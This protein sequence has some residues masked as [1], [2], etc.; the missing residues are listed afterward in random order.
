MEYQAILF[1]PSGDFVKDFRGCKSK[2]EVWKE[3]E[4]MGSRWIF[5]PI[6]FVATDKTIVDSNGIKA[7][8]GKRISTVKK[9]LESQFEKDGERICEA[10]NE[11]VP[12]EYIY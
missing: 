1:H 2:E 7:F 3:I 6:A 8:E 11:G 4:N 9:M 12:L 10:L 5:Y